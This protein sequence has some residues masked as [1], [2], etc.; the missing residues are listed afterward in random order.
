M[1]FH[2]AVRVLVLACERRGPT[3]PSGTADALPE[4]EPG[5]FAAWARENPGSLPL[6]LAPGAVCRTVDGRA[7]RLVEV[8]DEGR[9]VLVCTAA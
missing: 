6:P 3:P 4:I 1:S 7:G 9:T 5:R 2:G 8:L